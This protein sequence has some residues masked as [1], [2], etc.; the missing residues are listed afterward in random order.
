MH[1]NNTTTL[2]KIDVFSDNIP[3]KFAQFTKYDILA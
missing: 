1:S 3:L 2:A